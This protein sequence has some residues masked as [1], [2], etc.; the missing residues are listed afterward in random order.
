MLSRRAALHALTCVPA[1]SMLGC[2]TKGEATSQSEPLSTDADPVWAGWQEQRFPGKR[3]TMYRLGQDPQN[4]HSIVKA[5]ASGSASMLRKKVG[6]AAHEIAEIDFSWRAEKIHVLS[7]IGDVSATD[8]P[9]RLVLAFDGDRSRWSAKDAMLNELS[10]LLMGEDMPY[11]SL[12]YTWCAQ[13]PKGAVVPN[14]RT[15]TV[16]NLILESGI[17]NQGRWLS[18]RRNVR[19]DFLRVF[20]EEPGNLTSMALMTDADNTDSQ[21]EGWYREIK[22]V[23]A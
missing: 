5:R 3:P 10:R 16:R 4:G 11:A 17:E 7:D 12:V 6:V 22:L 19:D 13:S 15:Q 21:T 9:L 8:A 20:G 1:L 2:A 14:P 23:R 18:Y